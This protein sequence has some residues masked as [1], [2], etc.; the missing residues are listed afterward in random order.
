MDDREYS[1]KDMQDFHVCH[2]AESRSRTYPAEMKNTE[3]RFQYI[4]AVI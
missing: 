3:Q 4:H 1:A 2:P